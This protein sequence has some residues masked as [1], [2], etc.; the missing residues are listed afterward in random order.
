MGCVVTRL[1]LLLHGGEREVRELDAERVQLFVCGVLRRWSAR[2][3]LEGVLFLRDCLGCLPTQARTSQSW[4]ESPFC[5]T[6]LS[7]LA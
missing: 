5:V 6:A 7:T 1:V 2:G 3:R 4:V